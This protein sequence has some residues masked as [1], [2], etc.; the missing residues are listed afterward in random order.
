ML[1]RAMWPVAAG[2][3]NRVCRRFESC[4][5]HSGQRRYRP[6]GRPAAS[7]AIHVRR[8]DILNPARLV[9]LV[10]LIVDLVAAL[11]LD[12]RRVLAEMTEL[13]GYQAADFDDAVNVGMATQ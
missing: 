13:H 3:L 8:R 12:A 5:G 2:F 10:A 4:R 1:V 9:D 6:S 11:V 7:R